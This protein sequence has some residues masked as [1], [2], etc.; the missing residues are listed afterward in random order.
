MISQLITSF[1]IGALT[2]CGQQ[3]G[4]NKEWQ[5]EQAERDRQERI[6]MMR[7]LCRDKN[8]CEPEIQ[9]LQ[10]PASPAGEP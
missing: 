4:K 8:I 2:F 3:W 6:E 1:I 9:Y 5:R 7:E 10:P